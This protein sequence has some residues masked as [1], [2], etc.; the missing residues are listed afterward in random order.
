MIVLQG[1]SCCCLCFAVS[2][3]FQEQI[4]Q[5]QGPGGRPC[6]CLD[7]QYDQVPAASALVRFVYT[8]TASQLHHDFL[9]KQ[10]QQLRLP[11]S[12]TRAGPCA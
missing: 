1:A 4:E 11:T 3:V 7:V 2:R 10:M 5:Q 8:G 6:I 12:D 9:S